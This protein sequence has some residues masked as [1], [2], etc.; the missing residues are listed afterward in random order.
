MRI[1][2]S[3]AYKC[4][5]C[6]RWGKVLNPNLRRPI[7]LSCHKCV[8]PAD[9]SMAALLRVG[10]PHG[11]LYRC[12]VL[13]DALV[14]GLVA[15]P[16]VKLPA[17]RKRLVY[18]YFKIKLCD[19]TLPLFEKYVCQIG[20]GARQPHGCCVEPCRFLARII[21]K[22]NSGDSRGHHNRKGLPRALERP[23]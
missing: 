4:R 1:K 11:L 21:R 19:S 16:G 14:E 7:N 20:R 8:R 18:T 12:Q 10:R 17:T 3:R 9:N 23:I 2:H 6:C 13:L 15:M 5:A 22:R